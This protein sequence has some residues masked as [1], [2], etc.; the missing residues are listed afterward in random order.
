MDLPPTD[1]AR[2]RLQTRSISKD[3]VDALWD[4]GRFHHDKRGAEVVFFDH[5]AR[6][7]LH[8]ERP[9][10]YRRYAERLNAYLVVAMDGSLIT[11]GWRTQRVLHS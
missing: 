9:D 4:F 11:A 7:R 1:H 8:R 6:K 10:L 2:L 5:A 3:L